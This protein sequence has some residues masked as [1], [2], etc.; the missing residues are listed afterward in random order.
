MLTP[1]TLLLVLGAP[2]SIALPGGPPV[3]MDYLA[4]DATHHR[5]WVPAGNTGNV[6][7][8]DTVIGLVTPIGGFVTRPS[9][10]SDRPSL[11]PSSATISDGIVWIG[12]RGDDRVCRFDAATLE[13]GLCLRLSTTPDGLA[14][15][16]STHEL[17]ITTPHQQ[18]LVVADES[19]GKIIATLKVDGAPEGYAV[20]QKRAVF[21]TNL[22]DRDQTL[23]IDVKTRKVTATWSP[24]C[25][26]EGP[27]GLALDS[28]RNLLVVACTDGARVLDLS[29]DGKVVGHLKTGGGVDNLD[30]FPERHLLYVASSKD[31]TLTFAN[32]ADDGALSVVAVEKTAEGARN[33]VVDDQGVAYVPDSRAGKLLVLKPPPP[34]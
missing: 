34:R 25:G 33:P 5:I 4:Y 20:D 16:A 14:H 17:W 18:S 12:N 19:S 15:V 32:L 30:Y 13:R 8:V 6:D 2:N 9:T 11:G 23:A 7:V 24:G 26:K 21:F 10:R 22:E 27:R 31:A 1:L 3:G 29:H 28:A